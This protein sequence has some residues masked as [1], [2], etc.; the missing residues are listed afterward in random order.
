MSDYWEYIIQWPCVYSLYVLNCLTIGHSQLPNNWLV[1]RSYCNI[2][3]QHICLE[4]MWADRCLHKAK[5]FSTKFICILVENNGVYTSTNQR[6]FGKKSFVTYVHK[7]VSQ[8]CN[9]ITHFMREQIIGDDWW[10]TVSSN[11]H[12]TEGHLGAKCSTYSNLEL[13]SFQTRFFL[14]FPVSRNKL[15]HFR[16]HSQLQTALKDRQIKI[17]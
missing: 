11:T 3:F 2:P 16:I 17:L 4:G 5:S 8:S 13:P 9:Y 6:N 14:V 10:K 1:K 15:K 7:L 12:L